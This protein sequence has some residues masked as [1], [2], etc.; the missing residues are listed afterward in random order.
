MKPPNLLPFFG[1]LVAIF[2]SLV[3]ILGEQ[4]EKFALVI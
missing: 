2:V 4:W 3:E 1:S